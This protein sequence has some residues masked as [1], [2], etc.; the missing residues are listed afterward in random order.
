MLSKGKSA[1]FLKGLSLLALISFLAVGFTGSVNQE[2]L[3]L[4]AMAYIGI[5]ISFYA[6]I[7][8]MKGEELYNEFKPYIYLFSINFIMGMNGI[9]LNQGRN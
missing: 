3:G 8:A 6:Q 7:F 9:N 5:K 4:I 1:S 2:A